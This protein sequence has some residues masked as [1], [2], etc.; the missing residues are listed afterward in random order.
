LYKIYRKLIKLISGDSV[1]HVNQFYYVHQ[2][3][4]NTVIQTLVILTLL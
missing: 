3:L 1:V 2:L 4:F